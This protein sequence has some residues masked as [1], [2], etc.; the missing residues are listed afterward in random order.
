MNLNHTQRRRK[1]PQ[2]LAL[3]ITTWCGC[4]ALLAANLP[5]PGI[6]AAPAPG[7]AQHSQFASGAKSFL[8][9]AVQN[10]VHP[11]VGEHATLRPASR[12]Y[13]T[14]NDG[15]IGEV[16]FPTLDRS[17]SVG[18]QFYVGDALKT[19][20]D[21]E[22]EEKGNQ[23]TAETVTVKNTVTIAN[24][25]S[26]RWQVITEPVNA[27][28]GWKITKNIFT[29]PSGD[30][31]IQRTTFQVTAPGKTL[32]DYRLY[33]S[34][35]PA[36]HGSVFG[37]R[38]QVV[39][40]SSNPAAGNQYLVAHETRT[41]SG[42]TNAVASA[43]KLQGASWALS[44][45]NTPMASA[46]WYGQ[47]DLWKDLLGGTGDRQ[48]SWAYSSA[49][50]DGA[51]NS[52][53]TLSGWINTGEGLPTNTL[54]QSTA[55]SFDVVMG[56]GQAQSSTAAVEAA[57]AQANAV[58][59]AN[60]AALQ[61]SYDN[62]WIAY[63]N[64]LF[65]NHSNF[66]KTDNQAYLAAMTL[67]TIQDKTNGAM[68][69]GLNK[70]WGDAGNETSKPGGEGYHGYHLVWARDLYKFSNA[71]LNAG[72]VRSA[73]DS[74][75]YLFKVQQQESNCG[76]YPYSATTISSCGNDFTSTGYSKVGH[77]PQNTWVYRN[78][79]NNGL[80]LGNTAAPFFKGSQLDESA[81]P[82]ILAWNVYQKLATP[83]GGMTRAQIL[84]LWQ[85]DIVKTADFLANNPDGLYTH[86][87]RWE[88]LSGYSPSTM[89]SMVAAMVVAKEFATLT[90][91]TSR[92]NLYDAR[93][94]QWSQEIETRTFTSNAQAYLGNGQYYIRINPNRNTTANQDQNTSLSGNLPGGSETNQKS[95][96]DGGFLELVRKN[97]RS[98]NNPSILD[99]LPEY[100]S[101]LGRSVNGH[102]AW[103]RYNFDAYGESNAGAPYGDG[104][105]NGRGRLWPIFTAERG[106]YEVAKSGTG[107]SGNTYK[108]A[109]QAF[110]TNGFIPEQIWPVSGNFPASLWHKIGTGAWT[111]NAWQVQL[112][113]RDYRGQIP[114]VGKATLSSAPLSWA[115]GEYLNLVLSMDHNTQIDAI[116][117]VCQKFNSCPPAARP[118]GPS[119]VPVSTATITFSV[120]GVPQSTAVNVVGSIPA[121]G[122]WA[123]CS[124]APLTWNSTT[125]RH[126][127]TVTVPA[128][129]VMEFKFVQTPCTSS[130]GWENFSGNRTTTAPVQGGSASL[131]GVWSSLS[132]VCG[133]TPV[134]TSVNFVTTATTLMGDQI[135]VVGSIPALG[136]W[137]L[138]S[139]IPM[140]TGA[141]TGYTYPTWGT[142]AAVAIPANTTFQFKFV[143]KTSSNTWMWESG[144][145]RT[146]TTSG[147]GTLS[148]GSGTPPSF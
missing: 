109:L 90:G 46:A 141:G 39:T 77:I 41:G 100:D 115:M 71:L 136:S 76:D 15:H 67:K 118:G 30:A 89:A 132:G 124:G 139:A 96:I 116:Q 20:L 131:C 56:F 28:H 34:H 36:I 31:L 74:V 6:G 35:K 73:Y 105:R 144:A 63:N 79:I 53:V 137:N 58:T 62:A 138:S 113:T 49:G 83:V 82:I 43:I 9:T 78:A 68:V 94:T 44:L 52:N 121:L 129:A 123:A 114:V 13:F 8:G 108:A 147:S 128:N 26:M 11:G 102:P 50:A 125:Q 42:I 38:A 66:V 88:E 148:C 93:A 98:P 95:M 122:S 4:G 64:G 23:S 101:L 146:C 127:A 61:T 85:S 47:N 1:L 80:A 18:T 7:T 120:Q 126:T 75:Q 104:N 37:D 21:R 84:A 119:A 99:T 5:N 33:L 24:P 130:P 143:K 25:R 60:V 135:F 10:A 54:G 106:I 133:T 32:K 19:W 48:M 29:N 117:V 27:A 3:A 55:F 81:M 22:E 59:T 97:V 17:Q 12:V 142:A 65:A 86:Q 145:N 134:G 72:D 140:V 51:A 16:H 70:P 112:P 69:A 91:D 87:E 14:G 92:A 107:L 45:N 2:M 103:F 57:I 111:N 40:H 110:S